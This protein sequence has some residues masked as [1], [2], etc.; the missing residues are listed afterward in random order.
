MSMPPS[1]GR[2]SLRTVP[3]KIAQVAT[4]SDTPPSPQLSRANYSSNIYTY[5]TR[6]GP[7]PKPLYNG[8]LDWVQITLNLETA[9]AVVVGNAANLM[10]VLSGKGELL[11]TNVPRTFNLARGTRLYVA[12]TA[13]NRVGVKIEQ[14]PWQQQQL[15]ALEALAGLLHPVASAL[16]AITARLRGGQ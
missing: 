12:A 4:P 11:Q 15:G 3:N 1:R 5:F 8:D 7:S 6:V 2:P 13:I 10:P 16:G 9:G 14:F